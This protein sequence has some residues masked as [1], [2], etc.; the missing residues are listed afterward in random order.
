MPGNPQLTCP[1]PAAT[2]FGIDC[3]ALT[4]SAL[5]NPTSVSATILIGGTLVPF[6]IAPPGIAY[7]ITYFFESFGGGPEGTIGTLAGN[8]SVGGVASLTCPGATEYSG[9][10]TTLAIPAGTLPPG[11][12]FKLTA[13]LTFAPPFPASAFLEGPL[14][15]T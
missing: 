7:T 6:L 4:P 5:F 8:S 15:Q 10:T 12:T 14:V 3:T 13:L 11:G 2:F 1:V 9:A